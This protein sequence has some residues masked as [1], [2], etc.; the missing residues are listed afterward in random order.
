MNGFRFLAPGQMPFTLASFAQARASRRASGLAVGSGHASLIVY[1]SGIGSVRPQKTARQFQQITTSGSLFFTD[2]F[3]FL[4]DTRAKV[5]DAN[6]RRSSR[7]SLQSATALLTDSHVS[8]P[9]SGVCFH[10]SIFLFVGLSRTAGTTDDIASKAGSSPVS[11]RLLLWVSRAI[12]VSAHVADFL[13]TH[14]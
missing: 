12:R 8:V 5:Y 9:K 1:Y 3:G 7:R 14:G 6:G 10:A 2:C 13:S 4:V 11:A